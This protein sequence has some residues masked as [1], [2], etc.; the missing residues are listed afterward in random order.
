M[1]KFSDA[2]GLVKQAKKI[3][4]EL[5]NT[6]IEAA[7]K[8]GLVRVVFNGEQHIKSV[9]IDESLLTAS[10]KQ[11]LEKELINVI[12]QAISKSQA[13]AAEQMKEVAGSLN[14]PGF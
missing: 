1:S 5:K 3:Q 2:M 8:D 12:S 6:E 7:S 10:N 11:H 9:T 4:K 13:I 14:L